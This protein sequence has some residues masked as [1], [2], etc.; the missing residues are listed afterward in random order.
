MTDYK[1]EYKHITAAIDLLESRLY[2][3]GVQL[4]TYSTFPVLRRIVDQLK[5]RHTTAHNN[6]IRD[7]RASGMVH[8]V[9]IT[10]DTRRQYGA[11]S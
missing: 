6:I 1:T 2:P 10:N 4:N 3:A 8:G 5:M 11:P 9:P 7:A